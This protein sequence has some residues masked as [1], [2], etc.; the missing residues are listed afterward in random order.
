[1]FKVEPLLGDK[2][3]TFLDVFRGDSEGKR[4]FGKRSR[5][6]PQLIQCKYYHTRDGAGFTVDVYV[7]IQDIVDLSVDNMLRSLEA[8]L[9]RLACIL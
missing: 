3:E 6:P 1:M 9:P 4:V 5:L 7:H 8:Y 2:L